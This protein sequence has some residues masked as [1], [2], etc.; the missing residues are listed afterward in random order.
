MP[1]IQ[2]ADLF[3]EGFSVS[4]V[5]LLDSVGG[6]DPAGK[7]MGVRSAVW[8]PEIESFDEFSNEELIGVWSDIRRVVFSVEAGFVS[9]AAWSRM[10]G[11][12]VQETTLPGDYG[13]RASMALY[14][15]GAANAV[16]IPVKVVFP[17]RDV[18]GINHD[19]EV[20]L[21]SVKFKPPRLSGASYKD[22]V[23]VTYEGTIVLSHTDETGQVLDRP[24]FGRMDALD[25]AAMFDSGTY[26]DGTYDGL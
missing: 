11:T 14:A 1:L 21:F 5:T 15:K 6:A 22:G 7:L 26:D 18:E 2:S 25:L 12:P 20:V 9:L 17:A 4:E 24:A 16:T 3:F 23:S 13:Y 19:V 10:T 8:E